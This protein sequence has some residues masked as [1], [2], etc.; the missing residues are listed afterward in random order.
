MKRNRWIMGGLL[1]LATLIG[2]SACGAHHGD[3][4][5]KQTR[6]SKRVARSLDLNAEQKLAFEALLSEVGA[7][8]ADMLAQNE[9]TP[10][11]IA[12]MVSGELL[13]AADLNARIASQEG[14]FIAF[15]SEAVQRFS[16][17]HAT[18]DNDQRQKLS[19]HIQKHAG[20][21]HRN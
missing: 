7:L 11:V 15:R 10:Q 20:R 19:R 4:D 5:H 18:L 6:M 12:E 17:F 2:L 13:D 8:R 21:S 14:R 1:T 3:W 16:E 9:L